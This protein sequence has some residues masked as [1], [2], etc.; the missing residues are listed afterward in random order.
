[1]Q[2][3]FNF[4]SFT[5]INKTIYTS[6]YNT[7]TLLLNKTVTSYNIFRAVQITPI[8]TSNIVKAISHKNRSKAK[9]RSTNNSNI[10]CNLKQ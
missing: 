6:I 2:F 1:M 7:K 3:I 10:K 4:H 5:K 9:L 8:K